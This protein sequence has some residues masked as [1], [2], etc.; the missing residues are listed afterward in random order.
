MLHRIRAFGRLSRNEQMVFSEAYFLQ[1][2]I[3]LILKVI[4]FKWIPG[5]FSGP[6]GQTLSASPLISLQ[7]KHA[8]QSAGRICPWKNKCLVQ[9]LAARR[10]LNRRKII[11]QLFLGVILTDN[12]KMRAHA[13]LKTGD[14]EIVEKRDNFRELF[15][16]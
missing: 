11:S 3:G 1:L 4:P 8:T 2:A 15:M 5:L 10:M 7:I 13:W 16:F 14:F 9:S 12:N 6:S